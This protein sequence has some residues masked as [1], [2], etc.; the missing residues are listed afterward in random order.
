MIKSKLARATLVV[1]ASAAL[2]VGMS[3]SAQAITNET[4]YL[5]DDRGYMHFHDDGDVFSVCDTR[6]DGYGVSGNL[7][8]ADNAGLFTLKDNTDDG[9]AKKGYDVGIRAVRMQVWWDGNLS[10]WYYSDW[11]RE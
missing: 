10:K 4:V 7:F 9:C 3:S 6:A 5:P 1:G 8:N 11:F 2:V